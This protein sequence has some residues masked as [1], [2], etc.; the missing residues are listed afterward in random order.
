MSDGRIT[1]KA[2]YGRHIGLTCVNHPD[3]KWST[4]NIDYIGARTIFFNLDYIPGI[5][6][7]DCP[8]KNLR[9]IPIDGPDVE[10]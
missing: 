6:E 10:P 1:K 9:V 5:V 4:K 3:L 7:C 2:P 8:A